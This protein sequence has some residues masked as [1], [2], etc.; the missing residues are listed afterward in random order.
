VRRAKSA[1]ARIA[2]LATPDEV[3]HSHQPANHF[4]DRPNGLERAR[5]PNADIVGIHPQTV[6]Q[7]TSDDTIQRGRCRPVADGLSRIQQF[8]DR[9]VEH[10]ESARSRLLK[11]AYRVGNVVGA[12]LSAGHPPERPHWFSL[13]NAP[14][15]ALPRRR[16]LWGRKDFELSRLS[17]KLIFQFAQKF[18]LGGGHHAISQSAT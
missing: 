7:P 17:F 3:S 12:E 4:R 1:G 13:R 14:I 6:F 5:R 9:F 11:N 2:K 15:V 8:V 18:E 16:S 10:I